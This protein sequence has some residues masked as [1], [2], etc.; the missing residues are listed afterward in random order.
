VLRCAAAVTGR[1]ACE[2]TA[3]STWGEPPDYFEHVML[4]N[5]R[6]TVP[7]AVAASRASGRDLAPADLEPGYVPA[8]RSGRPVRGLVERTIYTDKTAAP[9]VTP[10]STPGTGTGGGRPS[11]WLFT[12][13]RPWRYIPGH[14]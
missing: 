4:A 10:R 12:R 1:P 13:C 3:A 9:G 11:S 5:G 2:L 8:V 14:D 6:C 7:E